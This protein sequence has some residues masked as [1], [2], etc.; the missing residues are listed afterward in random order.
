MSRADFTLNAEA[1]E[2]PMTCPASTPPTGA[3]TGAALGASPFAIPSLPPVGNAA[4]EANPNN[5]AHPIETPEG[6]AIE[7]HK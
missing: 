3:F 2:P 6:P 1:S 5:Q 4:A 7:A